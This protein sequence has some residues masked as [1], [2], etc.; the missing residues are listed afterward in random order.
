MKIKLIV[1]L[2]ITVNMKI[3]TLIVLI[4]TIMVL[5]TELMKMT[6]EVIITTIMTVIIMTCRRSCMEKRETLAF[7]RNQ[8][9]I[10]AWKYIHK[11]QLLKNKLSIISSTLAIQTIVSVGRILKNFPMILFKCSMFPFIIIKPIP[12]FDF[13]FPDLGSFTTY[14]TF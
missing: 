13:C 3:I 4:V 5:I 6:T 10:Y 1:V 7:I 2:K 11:S 8:S 14:F 12:K 9:G